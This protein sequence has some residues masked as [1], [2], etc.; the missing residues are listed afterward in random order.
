MKTLTK[1]VIEILEDQKK[2]LKE[3]DLLGV[4]LENEYVHK[5]NQ[6]SSS[7]IRLSNLREI[8]KRQM[9]DFHIEVMKI[10]LINEGEKKWSDS[11]EPKI[12]EVATKYYNETFNE[13]VS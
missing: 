6:L 13:A 10:G 12:R 5:S 11:Y 3:M 7:Q 1:Q 8:E 2:G 4:L 9:I